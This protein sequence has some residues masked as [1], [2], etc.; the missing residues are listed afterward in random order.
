MALL[1]CVWVGVSS[2][3]LAL[4][5]TVGA[6]KTIS[7]AETL[8]AKGT[9]GPICTIAAEG[10]MSASVTLYAT[11]YAPYIVLNTTH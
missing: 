5:V 10:T 9:I 1:G 4:G 7:A 3:S 11:V 2:C 8:S 6:I